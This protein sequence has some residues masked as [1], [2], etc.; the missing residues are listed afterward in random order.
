MPR[1]F[2]MSLGERLEA[3]RFLIRDRGQTGHRS[4]RC[5]IRTLRPADPQDPAA[6]FAHG[7]DL[8]ACGRHLARLTAR[9]HSDYRDLGYVGLVLVAGIVV[10]FGAALTIA[11]FNVP[12]FLVSRIGAIRKGSSRRGE[13]RKADRKL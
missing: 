1:E 8:R 11:W 5:R 13:R 9:P 4:V 10:F 3:M 12:G 7:C 6:G 2:V